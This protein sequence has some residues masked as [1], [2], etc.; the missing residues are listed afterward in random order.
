M[1]EKVHLAPMTI[2]SITSFK[3]KK[4]NSTT[5]FVL[6]LCRRME[7]NSKSCLIAYL[8]SL[9]TTTLDNSLKYVRDSKPE[10]KVR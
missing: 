1:C 9:Q 2:T 5:I 8:N 4:V 7:E 3:T 6:G 10:E